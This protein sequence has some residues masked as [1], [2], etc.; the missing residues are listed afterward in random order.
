MSLHYH[1]LKPLLSAEAPAWYP[2]ENCRTSRSS[3]GGGGG[4]GRGKAH[5]MSGMEGTESWSKLCILGGRALI[6]EGDM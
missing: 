3:G 1:C 5:K 4:G 2:N 6:L